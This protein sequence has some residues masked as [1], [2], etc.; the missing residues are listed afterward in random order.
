MAAVQCDQARNQR[1]SWT[2]R[3]GRGMGRITAAGKRAVAA[4]RHCTP[5]SP[6]VVAARQRRALTPFMILEASSACASS[7]LTNKSKLPCFK[8]SA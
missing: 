7:A 2:P 8:L 3:S 1:S 5:R 4:A 6:Q